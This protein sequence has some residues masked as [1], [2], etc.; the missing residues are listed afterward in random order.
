MRRKTDMV[1]QTFFFCF[2]YSFINAAFFHICGVI[3][4][5]FNRPNV[6]EIYFLQSHF[7]KGFFQNFSCLIAISSI[8]Q[9]TFS[10]NIK[11]TAVHCLKCLSKNILA[12]FIAIIRSCIKIIHTQLMG[13]MNYFDTVFIVS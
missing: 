8:P 11:C 5:C 7:G 2:Q 6:K 4:H 12:V 10:R 13:T 1:N 3:F 9:S